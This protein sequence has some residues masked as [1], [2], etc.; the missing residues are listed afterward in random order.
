M[1]RW[2][3]GEE[4][5][6]CARITNQHTNTRPCT[7]RVVRVLCVGGGGARAERK[8]EREVAHTQRLLGSMRRRRRR[9]RAETEKVAHTNV[10]MIR[11]SIARRRRR[12]T[13]R[14]VQLQQALLHAPDTLLKR[15]DGQ[16]NVEEFGGGIRGG[17]GGGAC[18]E[19]E[20]ARALQSCPLLRRRRGRS[21]RWRRLNCNPSSEYSKIKKQSYLNKDAR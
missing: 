1:P 4:G 15:L 10:F 6:V 21:R 3:G 2:C 12:P 11:S 5:Y 7:R 14:R 18:A 17:G 19:R 8:C 13:W 16:Y 9:A 20:R